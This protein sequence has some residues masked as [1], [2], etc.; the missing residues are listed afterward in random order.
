MNL[1]DEADD[2]ETPPRHRPAANRRLNLIQVRAAAQQQAER[3][4]LA[5]Q[6]PPRSRKRKRKSSTPIQRRLAKKFKELHHGKITA[7]YDL[8]CGCT[9]CNHVKEIP[10]PWFKAWR[11]RYQAMNSREKAQH[12]FYKLL[13]LSAAAEAKKA[14]DIRRGFRFDSNGVCIPVDPNTVK[15]QKYI[16]SRPNLVWTVTDPNHP[17]GDRS[18]NSPPPKQ[19]VVCQKAFRIMLRGFSGSMVTRMRD[20]IAQGASDCWDTQL[21]MHRER[22]DPLAQS[23]VAFGIWAAWEMCD[24]DPTDGDQKRFTGVE[25][26]DEMYHI[27]QSWFETEGKNFVHREPILGADGQPTFVG[28]RKSYFREVM[29]RYFGQTIKPEKKQNNFTKCSYCAELKIQQRLYP[30]SSAEAKAVRAHRISHLKWQAKQRMKYYRH[31]VKAMSF[32]SR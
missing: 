25:N 5:N 8:H 7:D 20:L 15:G 27:Y 6:T 19:V 31:R 1:V 13:E 12:C 18:E 11:S 29:V 4:D 16:N 26:Y 2:V 14:A 24:T 30:P 9:T 10:F 21:Q 22:H 28:A 3:R 32:P 17:S 23:V